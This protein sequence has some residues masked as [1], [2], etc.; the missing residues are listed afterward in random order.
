MQKF[1]E[2]IY[3]LYAFTRETQQTNQPDIDLAKKTDC[4]TC[5]RKEFDMNKP[6]K[7]VV[8]TENIF[9]DIGIDDAEAENL[10][11]RSTL[12]QPVGWASSVCPTSVMMLTPMLGKR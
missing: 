9:R 2:E 10:K 4:K 7:R 3:A 1:A 11:L 12:M 5:A 8:S 6:M